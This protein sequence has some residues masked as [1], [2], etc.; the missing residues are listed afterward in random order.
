MRGPSSGLDDAIGRALDYKEMGAD[1]LFVEAPE[2]LDEIKVI[3]HELPGPLL[4]NIAA[5]D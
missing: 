2:N 4:L 5:G 3:A 1:I